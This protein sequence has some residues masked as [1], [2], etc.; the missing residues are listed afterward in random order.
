[1][2]KGIIIIKFD[3]DTPYIMENEQ[4]A[5]P[6]ENIDEPG[7]DE[8]LD[9]E[10]EEDD[11]DDEEDYEDD[12][13]DNII[14]KLEKWEIFNEYYADK[15]DKPK[16]E[17]LESIMRSFIATVTLDDLNFRAFPYKFYLVPLKKHKETIKYCII[18]IMDI[19]ESL[20]IVKIHPKKIQDSLLE[21]ISNKTALTNRLR[22]IYIQKNNI[23]EKV[24]N[25]AILKNEIGAIA[26]KFI[27]E[28]KYE[29][30]KKIIKLAKDIP[31]K[32]VT[33]FTKSK[34]EVKSRHFKSAEKNLRDALNLA[35]KI[36]DEG[37]KDYLIL[38]IITVRKN[39]SYQ[40]EV[41]S[42]YSSIVKRLAKYN[43]FLSYS[44]QIPKL[45][46]CMELLD[47]LEEDEQI[48]QIIELEQLLVEAQQYV[49]SL[50]ETDRKIKQIVRVLKD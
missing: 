7:E 11:D 33:A 35:K 42:K 30:A 3:L 31:S 39:P 45:H 1:M 4:I 24:E 34:K 16:K 44:T 2:I 43:K 13:S 17:L 26:N 47:K 18:Y 41:K 10:L 36:N 29:D 28:G 12:E 20:E 19:S 21:I 50:R 22:N 48:D 14:P 49:R 9:E 37:L 38:K 23:L 32:F 5:Q 27:D 46:R 15:K 25:E 8:D 40:K 6:E